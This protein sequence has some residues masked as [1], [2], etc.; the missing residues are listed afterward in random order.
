VQILFS[1]TL[2]Y[3][4]L[5][6]KEREIRLP[7]NTFNFAHSLY[8]HKFV[9]LVADRLFYEFLCSIGVLKVQLMQSLLQMRVNIPSTNAMKSY[10]QNSIPIYF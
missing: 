3:P 2:T 7:I 4:F 5:I 6:I 1:Y 8:S 9:F 10:T